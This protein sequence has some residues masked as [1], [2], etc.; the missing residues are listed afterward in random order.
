M[1]VSRRLNESR[2]QQCTAETEQAYLEDERSHS[3]TSTTRHG[4]AKY[5]TFQAVASFC[6]SVNHI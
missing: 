1:P 4:V 5:E 6:F 3:G 2:A